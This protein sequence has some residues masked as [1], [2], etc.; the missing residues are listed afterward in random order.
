MVLRSL[1]AAVLVFLLVLI[2]APAQADFTP[3]A[4]GGGDPFYPQAGNG[5]YDVK[6]YSLKLDY[7]PQTEQLAGDVTISARATQDLSSF[8]LDLRDLKVSSVTV[9][10]AD[11]SFT[12]KG[13]GQGCFRNRIHGCRN[14][15]NLQRYVGSKLATDVYFTRKNL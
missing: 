14:Q 11:A 8:N 7:E 9:N 12:R 13:D 1:P 2:A 15:R 6:N 4:G 10:G 5:G 3:G